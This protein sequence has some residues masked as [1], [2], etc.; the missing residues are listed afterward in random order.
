MQ[1]RVTEPDGRDG[2]RS[3]LLDAG[4]PVALIGAACGASGLSGAGRGRAGMS[5]ERHPVIGR[6]IAAGAVAMRVSPVGQVDRVP[7]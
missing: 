2:S 7:G 5:Q 4:A 6:A 3:V 1:G